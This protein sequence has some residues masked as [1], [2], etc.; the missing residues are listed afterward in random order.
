MHKRGKP[1][2]KRFSAGFPRYL[3]KASGGRHGR[4]RPPHPRLLLVRSLVVRAL[5]RAL[6]TLRTGLRTAGL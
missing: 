1:A 4:G 5:L 3:E 6:G 2:E